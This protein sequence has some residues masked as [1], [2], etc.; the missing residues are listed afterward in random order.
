[1][2]I[3]VYEVTPPRAANLE[4]GWAAGK[5]YKITDTQN[6]TYYANPQF[7]PIITELK[8]G[9]K[10]DIKF[11]EKEIG[12]NRMNFVDSITQLNSTGN[13]PPS[14]VMQPSP[15]LREVPPPV[16]WH[17]ANEG[18]QAGG[19][20]VANIDARSWSIILQAMIN[21]N[22]DIKPSDKLKWYLIMYSTGP[23]KAFKML[24]N[25]NSL[26]DSQVEDLDNTAISKMPDDNIPF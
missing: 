1:M 5:T 23:E 4:K 16:D 26:T 6:K 14:N 25:D 11:K 22:A 12:N 20:D 24:Q 9:N 17:D 7:V 8:A 3:E 18:G 15:T 2:Q 10:V 13:P 19:F 21:R